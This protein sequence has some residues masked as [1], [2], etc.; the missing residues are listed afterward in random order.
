MDDP[1]VGFSLANAYRKLG[2]FND[3]AKIMRSTKR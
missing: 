3:A 2:R 1:D